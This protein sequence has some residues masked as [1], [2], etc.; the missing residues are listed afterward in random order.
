MIAT[1]KLI[2]LAVGDLDDAEAEAVEEHVL[3]CSACAQL[4]ER[5]LS[6]GDG[7][8]TLVRSSALHVS[9]TPSLVAELEKAGLITRVY[10]IPAGGSVDCTVTREDRFVAAF[11]EADLRGVERVDLVMEVPS[12]VLRYDDVTFD[13]ERGVV[14]WV[15]SGDFVRSLPTMK[16]SARVYAVEDGR[17]RELGR[18]T[19][20][21]TA[22][23][24]ANSAPS[25]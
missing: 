8:R 7:I 25:S 9:L 10:R 16:H 15:S 5:V 19:F 6:L 14:A 13:V 23:G 20:N 22:Y 3:S 11:L 18:Y 21:H 4:L 1:E 12:G 2:A 17:E 24:S